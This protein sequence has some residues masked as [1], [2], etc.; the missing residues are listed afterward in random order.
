MIETAHGPLH[1]PAYFPDATRAVVRSVDSRD[2][3]AC[4]V[5]GVVVNAFHLSAHP[6]AGLLKRAGGV[7]AFMG[8]PRPVASD[9]GGFQLMS[10]IR[11][12]PRYGTVSARGIHFVDAD[13]TRER[14]LFTPERSIRLQFDLGA[15]LMI[16]LDDCPSPTASR[17]EVAD[18]GRADGAVG[19]ALPG[20]VRPAPGGSEE[21]PQ[22]RRP[23]LFGVVQGGYDPALRRRCAEELLPLGFDGFGFGGWPLTPAGDLAEEIL[24]L[25]RQSLIPDPLPRFA[26]GVGKPEHIVRCYQ[27]GWRIFDTVLPTRDARHQRLY[28][29]DAPE[30]GSGG[31]PGHQLLPFC[32][33]R[34]QKAHAADG[35]DLDGVRLS[36]LPGL[37]PGLSA[38]SVRRKRR[39]GLS[40]GDAAQPAVLYPVAGACFQALRRFQWKVLP[41]KDLNSFVVHAKAAT[42]VGGGTRSLSY[43]PGSHD[44]QFHEGSFSYLDSYFG[45]AD[46]IGQEVV[47]FEGRPVWAM[48]Y[49][50]RILE[51][52]RIEAQEAG[53]VIQHSLSEMYRQGRFLGGFEHAVGRQHLRG[54]QRRRRRFVHRH[55]ADH[56]RRRGGVPARLPRRPDQIDRRSPAQNAARSARSASHISSNIDR[57]SAGEQTAAV[58]GSSSS[59]WSAASRLRSSTAS[60][61]SSWTYMCAASSAASCGGSGPKRIGMQAGAVDQHRHLDTALRPAGCRSAL[62]SAHCRG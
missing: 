20:R 7:H 33:R 30:P 12:N 46:F 26:L 49:Y 38:P 48:N 39:A 50:G 21:G 34:G 56:A 23:L 9:S 25:T 22:R 32:V 62:R 5:Q 37:F 19:R 55:R 10:M 17:E 8:W 11:E 45:G 60:T 6:G 61:I 28:A 42:Y 44:L 47:Y 35:A 57:I 31:R 40:A 41:W 53:Q 16:C 58:S 54:Q 1:L 59:A 18:L 2:L 29:F 52:A 24:A 15:D 27:M 36:L 3:E 4:G 14:T 43:R 13:G 51:P